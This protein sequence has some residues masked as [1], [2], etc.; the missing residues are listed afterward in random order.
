M[1]NHGGALRKEYFASYMNLIINAMECSVQKARDITFQR[2]FRNNTKALGE[3][4]YKEFL[5]AYEEL[6]Q[7]KD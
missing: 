6:Q 3:T 4:S 1:I 7:L 2:L 5:F